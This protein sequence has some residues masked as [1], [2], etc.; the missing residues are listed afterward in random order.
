MYKVTFNSD[1]PS[2][3]QYVRF[4]IPVADG[5]SAYVTY[6]AAMPSA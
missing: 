2:L 6:D 4:T 3:Y 5:A 1:F